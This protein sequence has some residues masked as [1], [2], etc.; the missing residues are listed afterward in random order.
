MIDIR[1]VNIRF[2]E[3]V[4]LRDFSLT[5]AAGK[6]TCIL[7]PSGCGKTTLLRIAAGLL[8]PDS[9]AVIRPDSTRSSFIFQEDRLLPWF[10]ALAN[11][12]ALGIPEDSA[13][14]ALETMLLLEDAHTMPSELS[15]GMQRRLAIAR[16]LA[17][18]GDVFFLDEPLRGLDMA[19]AR[20][21]LTA[22]RNALS[23]RTALLITH[24]PEEAFALGDTLLLADG[25]PVQVR[26]TAN[27]HDFTDAEELKAWLNANSP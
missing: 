26:K 1:Q 10:D 9:G 23:G 12:T 22:I 21:V 8:E 6:T 2:A 16:A 4:I 14:A 15:G 27:I 13:L 3:K 5:L 18:G 7:G 19:T 24:S 25:P 17:F 20:P 11:L